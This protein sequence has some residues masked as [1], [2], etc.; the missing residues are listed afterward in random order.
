ML[1]LFTD[2]TNLK[3]DGAAKFFAYGGLLVDSAKLPDLHNGIEQIRRTTG[4]RPGDELKFDTRAR[5]PHVE[6]AAC[7]AAKAAVVDLCI[8]L[9]LKFIA[10]VVLHAIAKSKSPEDLVKW[11]ANHVIGRFN[12]YC[13]QNGT[14][15]TVVVDRLPSG[16]EYAY[17]TDKF[18]NGLQ[19]PD[20]EPVRLDR[21][22]LFA[23]S[24]VGASHAC[25]AMDIVLGSF[26]YCIN[27]PRN[28]EA[29]KKMMASITKLIWHE[30]QGDKI[31]ALGKGLI[32]APKTVKVDAYKTEYDELLAHINVLI[33]DME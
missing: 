23:A 24:T 3:P 6:I 13:G 16:V 28:L 15:G 8:A 20:D 21:I 14:H 17:L 9:D 30:R 7:T 25:S 1:M 31:Y 26:R 10:Y 29:A 32:F 18:A 12:Y 5:P 4:Y 2:E 27:S 33:A 19:F 11:G 22:H